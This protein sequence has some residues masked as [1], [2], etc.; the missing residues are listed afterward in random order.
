[1]AENN[2]INTED[3][4]IDVLPALGSGKKVQ[5]TA[6]NI[7]KA[8]ESAAQTVRITEE[9]AENA[10]ENAAEN[11]AENVRKKADDMVNSDEYIV[12]E[13]V[14]IG[15]PRK[16]KGKEVRKGAAYVVKEIF[17]WVLTFLI[18]V[19]L[20]LLVNTY[21]IRASRVSGGSM[22][23]TLSDGQNVWLSRLPYLFSDYK[24]GD[25]IVFD[26][27]QVHRNFLVEIRESLQYNAITYRFF[28]A[29]ANHKYYI[30]RVIGLP[31]DTVRI[32][33]DGVYV[34]D[35]KLTEDYVNPA[36]TPNYSTWAGKSWTVGEGELFV[37]GD[38]RNHSSDSRMF[39]VITQNSV[40]GKV[41]RS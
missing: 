34:N 9:T 37:L 26:H 24:R 11:A 4:E 35:V 40:L 15:E 23:Q 13:T 30:K 6:E 36:E 29:S 7:E 41:V 3:V 32:E 17:S 1:M 21:I 38:N 12:P 16:K 31:G 33:L 8:A 39:G 20:A 28:N 14:E 25:I 18:A 22:N 2:G 5:E 27:E 19:V 10:V